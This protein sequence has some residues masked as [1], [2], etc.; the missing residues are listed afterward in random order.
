MKK[1]KIPVE[2]NFITGRLLHPKII[3]PNQPALLL[4]HGWMSNDSGNIK[5]A[6][7][8]IKLGFICLTINFRG[9]GDSSGELEKLSRQDHL[10][11]A[12][13]AYDYLMSHDGIDKDKIGIIGTSYG[14]YIAVLLSIYRKIKWLVI[15]SPAIYNNDK[16]EEPSIKMIGK[17]IAKDYRLKKIIP[18]ENKALNAISEFMGEILLVESGN[19][20]LIPAQTIDNYKNSIYDKNKLTHIIILDADHSLSKP[21]WNNQFM[22]I[23]IQ[24]LKKRI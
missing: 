18:L 21:K 3:K 22:E 4:L 14:S 11:D 17:I 19:D 13:S 20:E 12:I 1:I 8:L 15:R 23:L 9:H 24:W 16:F 5:R 2:S 7:E 10:N 6:E